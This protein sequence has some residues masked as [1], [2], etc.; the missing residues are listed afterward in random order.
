MGKD[1][2]VVGRKSTIRRGL[3][4]VRDLD[5]FR[6]R[7][8]VLTFNVHTFCHFFVVHYKNVSQEP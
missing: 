8:L 1:L 4:I 2:F 6:K 3:I 7:S 5:S